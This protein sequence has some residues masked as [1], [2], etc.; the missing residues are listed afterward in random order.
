M[1]L[2]S[3]KEH[4]IQLLMDQDNKVI[5]LSGKWG[6]GKSHLWGEVRK[7]SK[8]EAIQSALYVSLFGLSD[9]SQ[10]K[11]KVVQ[12]AL[13]SAEKH[14]AAWERVRIGMDGA[15]KVLSSVHKGFSALDDL[16]LLAVP[17][18]LKNRVIVLD[19]IERKHEKLMRC[20]VL[21][22]SLLSSMGR[23]SC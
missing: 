9:M 10:V 8:D 2:Q 14:S 4:L 15:K 6:T 13:P 18:I 12:S 23:G 21:L 11:L 19:D 3:T 5:T 22:M 17:S 16:V 7:A 1:S 20:L